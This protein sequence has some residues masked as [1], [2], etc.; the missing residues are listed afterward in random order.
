MTLA[1]PSLKSWSSYIEALRNS[2]LAAMEYIGWGVSDCRVGTSSR[3]GVGDYL[4]R[5]ASIS[6]AIAHARGI[7]RFVVSSVVHCG[8]EARNP[9]L[10]VVHALFE[11]VDFTH[12]DDAVIVE[13]SEKSVLELSRVHVLRL[14]LI[15]VMVADLGVGVRRVK[16]VNVHVVAYLDEEGDSDEA[17]RGG[18]YGRRPLDAEGFDAVHELLEQRYCGDQEVGVQEV[19]DLVGVFSS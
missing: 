19:Y 13:H 18:L 7:T 10:V 1:I 12:T 17:V 16:S 15:K 11:V 8:A 14:H 9:Q 2:F 4:A 3:G 5:G 6:W